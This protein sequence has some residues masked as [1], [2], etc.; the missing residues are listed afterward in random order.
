[1]MQVVDDAIYRR[2]PAFII[3]TVDKFAQLPWV[4]H[5]GGLF[6]LV[7]RY[8]RNG[9]YGPMDPGVG[10]PLNGGTLSPPDLII[11]D[12]LHLISGPLG[13]TVGLFETA[14]DRLCR[15]KTNHVPR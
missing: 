8:D 3:A 9:F 11:Q 13:T 5:S 7:H 15:H 1:P 14:I 2:L 6:G 12:E 4:G 10:R